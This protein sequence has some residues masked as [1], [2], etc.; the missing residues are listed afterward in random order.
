[1]S[2]EFSPK[3]L[4]VIGFTFEIVENPAGQVSVSLVFSSSTTVPDSSGPGPAIREFDSLAD[5]GDL[6]IS[7][8]NARIE[9]IL[10][11]HPVNLP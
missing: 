11:H 7:S 10:I 8:L 6:V 9:D 5:A 2:E 1:M 3:L 4:G